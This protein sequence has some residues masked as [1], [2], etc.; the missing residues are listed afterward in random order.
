MPLKF[1][2]EGEISVN[3]TS[4]YTKQQIIVSVRILVTSLYPAIMPTLFTK[5]AK[6]SREKTR[7]VYSQRNN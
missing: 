2:L 4:E 1:T 7:S 3:I 5:Y 6:N